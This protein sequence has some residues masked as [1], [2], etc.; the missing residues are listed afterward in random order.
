MKPN[1]VTKAVLLFIAWLL[2]PQTA[3]CFYSPST[4]RWLSRDP[5]EEKGGLNLYA[6]VAND[7][8]RKVDRL[9]LFWPFT[10]KPCCC[11][12]AE[13]ILF[14]NIQ[15]YQVAFKFGHSFDSRIRL[16]YSSSAVKGDCKL[17]WWERSQSDTSRPEDS[18][19]W[20]DMMNG[21]TAST[22]HG[23]ID[24]PRPCPGSVVIP[25]HDEP[26]ISILVRQR[27]VL[28]FH[29]EV[30]STPLCPC[31]WRMVLITAKQILEVDG[32]R[33]ILSQEFVPGLTK[34]F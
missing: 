8:I 18:Y 22:F 30:H 15:P 32:S 29:I 16:K 33:Q 25:V 7:P 5:I 34:Y 26:T 3:N 4:G 27:R 1:A 19:K 9:G 23:W 20:T 28:D 11:C 31:K 14:Q 6:F 10:K 24:T 21:P 12:C 17:E 2:L 13:D